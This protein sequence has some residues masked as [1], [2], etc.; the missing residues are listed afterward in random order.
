[1]RLSALLAP[2]CCALLLIGCG[3]KDA[4]D[5]G[6]LGCSGDVLVS[7][8]NG[9]WLTLEDCSEDDMVCHDL[10]DDSHCMPEGAMD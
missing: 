5:D 8:H 10:G 4:C 9:E 2:L 6:A 7:C 1:M 3:D